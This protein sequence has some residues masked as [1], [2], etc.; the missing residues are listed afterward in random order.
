MRG[1]LDVLE[2][3]ARRAIAELAHGTDR[4]RAAAHFFGPAHAGE[5]AS[6]QAAD[7]PDVSTATRRDSAG[8]PRTW[9]PGPT[10]HAKASR[11]A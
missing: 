1:T 2:A 11:P 10:S 8:S 4:L 7:T 3:I 6:M 9:T 5:V